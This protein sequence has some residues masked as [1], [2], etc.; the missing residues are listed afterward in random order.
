MRDGRVEVAGGTL[1]VDPGA[2]VHDPFRP[3]RHARRGVSE[4]GRPPFPRRAVV[5][6]LGCEPPA[7]AEWVRRLVNRLVRRDVEA[8]IATPE[9]AAGSDSPPACT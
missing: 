7:D 5:V 9:P 3:D 8:R 2:H 6:F 4:Q 1:L